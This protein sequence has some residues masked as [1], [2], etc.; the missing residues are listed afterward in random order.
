MGNLFLGFPVARAKIADMIATA[1]PPLAHHTQHENGGSDEIDATGLTGA[2]GGGIALDALF[3]FGSTFDSIDGYTTTPTG[4]G[5]TT[6]GASGVVMSTGATGSSLARCDKSTTYVNPY[7]NFSRNK[8]FIVNARFDCLVSVTGTFEI[9]TGGR[10]TTRKIGFRVSDGVLKGAVANGSAESTVDLQTLGA[11]AYSVTRSLKAVFTT[12]SKC[13]FYI[14]G[15]LLGE[16]TTNLPSGIGSSMNIFMARTEN[17]AVA[18]DK[19]LTISA[20]NVLVAI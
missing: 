16:I 10:S 17:P 18:E 14:D 1:A 19:Y 20:Y 13:E 6:V 12:A 9:F 4:S 11:G 3:N 2:G 5:A 8:V 7:N 15:V